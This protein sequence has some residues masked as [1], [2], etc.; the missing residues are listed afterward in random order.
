VSARRGLEARLR[1]WGWGGFAVLAGAYAAALVVLL[2]LWE[3]Q[4]RAIDQELDAYTTTE[5]VVLSRLLI[6]DL[7]SD[8][9]LWETH[10]LE[11]LLREAPPAAPGRGS[12]EELIAFVRSNLDWPD[13]EIWKRS[14]SQFKG[15][16]LSDISAARRG[17]YEDMLEER[18]TGIRDD[19]WARVTFSDNLRGVVLKSDGGAEI[20]VG[21]D[22]PPDLLRGPAQATR[23]LPNDRLLVTLP[24][25]VQANRWG[26]AYL[27]VDRSIVVRLRESL[28]G[29]LSKGLWALLVLLVLMTGAWT[30][31]WSVLLRRVRR[32]VVAPIVDLAHRM[33]ER[34]GSDESGNG[35]TSEP[36]WLSTAFDRLMDRLVRQQ[37]Q[38][39]AAQKLGLM[40]RVG[41]GLSHEINNALNPARLRLDELAMEGRAP[42]KEDILALR[43]YLGHAQQVLKDLTFA[44]KRP[45]GPLR[46]LRPHEWLAVAR[47]LSD[48]ALQGL[49]GVDWRAGDEEPEVYG[50]PQWLVQVAVNLLLN[51][52]D[53]ASVS[54]GGGHVRVGLDESSEGTVLLT[55]S[56]DGP[57]V[58]PQVAEH[59]FE[60]YVT[61][62]PKGSGLGLFVVDQLVRRMGGSVDLR[63]GT[64]GG[65]V[66]EVR[67][68]GKMPSEVDDGGR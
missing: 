22:I 30:A 59:L 8:P 25:T 56:D 19:L 41:A 28:M 58:D 9:R 32:E 62:K 13:T 48:P 42:G 51:A 16:K 66:A 15:V 39:L 5:S 11:L 34:S 18:L 54:P 43:E 47:R 53:A 1:G 64:T 35:E 36:E 23:Q 27:L 14:E 12:D 49:A 38:L 61:S 4:T 26:T 52:R 60:P 45:S 10:R 2:L 29:T 31:W 63:R 55:I 3:N 24:L 57:G 40:E 33:E 20:S 68:K 6:Y 17:A 50:E 46:M 37:E 7:A 44:V 67:L 65:T 21:Q